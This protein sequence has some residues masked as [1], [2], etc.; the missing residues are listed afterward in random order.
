MKVLKAAGLTLEETHEMLGEAILLSRIGHPNIV[1]VF[2]AGLVQTAH[3]TCA[4]FTMEY[5]AGG[6]V[7]DFWKSHGAS[8]VPV[9]S[10][11]EIV[12]QVCRGLVVAHSETPP[13][14]H[15]DIK[16]Q[17]ILVGYDGG[18]L[19]ARLSDF[20]LAKRANPLTLLVSA[21]GTMRFKAPEVF[22][23]QKADSCACDVWAL[24]CTLY[25]LLTDQLPYADRSEMERATGGAF[26]EPL[27]P[28]SA[29]NAKVDGRLD[30]ITMRALALDPAERFRDAGQML[31][32]LEAWQPAIANAPANEIDHSDSLKAVFGPRSPVDAAAAKRQ[33]RAALRMARIPGRLM[34]AAD[35]LEEALSKC[36]SLRD[37]YEY[38]VR[39]WRRG[40]VM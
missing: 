18:G 34:E 33:A 27:R 7:E 5:V 32:Q 28:P 21:Q 3:G 20:G 38:H 23:N 16:P 29:F 31:P 14:I 4:Y 10:A 19:R 25:L 36:P 12:R 6:S 26:A 30:G 11:V 39:L 22:A 15:R 17:N 40:V 24:G 8:F 2:D 37:S 9:G 1:R 13:I 35:L